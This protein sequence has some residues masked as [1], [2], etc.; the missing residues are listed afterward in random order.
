MFCPG[1]YRIPAQGDILIESAWGHSHGVPTRAIGC[2]TFEVVCWMFHY[3]EVGKPAKMHGLKKGGVIDGT[4]TR[5]IQN[6][7][8]GLYH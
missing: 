7:N 6:H 2:L 1:G 8:L 4:R 3:S 5:N